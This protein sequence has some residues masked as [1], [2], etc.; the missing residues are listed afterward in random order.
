MGT[1]GIRATG[2]RADTAELNGPSGLA[3]DTSGYVYIADF[4]NNVIRKVNPRGVIST[5]AGSGARGYSG[6]AS[7]A[8]LAQ[9]N[10]PSAVAVDALGNVYI[11]DSGNNVIRKVDTSG[12]ITTIAGTG[13]AGYLGKRGPATSI[14]LD[15]PSGVAVDASGNVYIADSNNSMVR[16]VNTSGMMST[17]AGNGNRGDYGN[18]CNAGSAELNSPRGIAVDASGNVYIAEELSQRIRKVNTSGI[19]STIAGN[20][21]SGYSGDGGSAV[22]AKLNTPLG[23]AVDAAGNIYIADVGNNRIRKVDTSGIIST[24]AGN[25]TRGY[26]GDGDAASSAQLNSPRGVAVDASGNIYIADIGND[27]IRK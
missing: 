26:S 13:T 27:R 5:I 10:G 2:G 17:F 14:E 11:A 21:R 24:V 16:K 22:S 8:T 15:D 19:I 25:G 4:G 18:N 6:D 12:V 9:L 23:V 1:G 7:T 20:G 3:V